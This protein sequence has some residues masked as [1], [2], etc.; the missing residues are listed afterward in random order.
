MTLSLALLVIAGLFFVLEAISSR[1]AFNV[2]WWALGV[3]CY[4]FSLAAA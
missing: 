2:K 3:A 1:L 4:L